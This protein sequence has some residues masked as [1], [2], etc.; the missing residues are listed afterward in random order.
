V[1]DWVHDH[2]FGREVSDAE[3][4]S[5]RLLITQADRDWVGESIYKDP[6][7]DCIGVM[8]FFPV[9]DR[10]YGERLCVGDRCLG[11]PFHN[12]QGWAGGEFYDPLQ[13]IM[14][15]WVFLN[16]DGVFLT[17]MPALKHQGWKP[18]RW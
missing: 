10:K 14:L 16:P 18:R 1:S 8:R 11:S 6:L 13:D 2:Q 9:A 17:P 7:L 3:L 4:T 5:A 12:N 15:L